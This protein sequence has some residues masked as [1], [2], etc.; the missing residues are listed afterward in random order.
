MLF[1]MPFSVYTGIGGPAG[2]EIQIAMVLNN[3]GQAITLSAG[4]V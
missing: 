1:G 2:K 4:A 3:N